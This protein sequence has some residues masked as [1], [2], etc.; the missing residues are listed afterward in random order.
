VAIERHVISLEAKDAVTPA[1]QKIATQVQRTSQQVEQG[2]QRAAR[3][4]QDWSRA[5]SGLG[6]A[7]GGIT[8]AATR[9]AQESEVSQ[10]RLQASIEA[11]GA[12]YDDYADAV[13]NAARSALNL[14][15]DDEEA[16]DALNALTQGTGDAS[17][18]LEDLALVEDIAR[19]RG[20]DLAAAAKIVIAAEQ[21]RIGSL[22]RLGIAIDENAS[23]E[24]A[25]AAL[26]TKFAGQ[27]EAYADTNAATWDRVQNSIENALEGA[28]GALVDYQGLILGVSTAGA[29]LGPLSDAFTAIG[30]KAKLAAAG[31]GALSLAMGPLGIAAAAAAGAA[32][33]YLLIKS[34]DGGD[35]SLKASEA[36]VSNLQQALADLA[37]EGVSSAVTQQIGN[38]AGTLQDV[39]RSSVETS[40]ELDRV[41]EAGLDYAQMLDSNLAQGNDAAADAARRQLENL[42]ALAEELDRD[43]LTGE[44]FTQMQQDLVDIFT[45]PNP[46]N[47]GLVEARLAELRAE[48]EAGTISADDLAW[49]IH[50]LN[51]NSD[52]Y[53]LTLEEQARQQAA[54]GNEMGNS[55]EEAAALA[56]NMKV[57]AQR[58]K[59][60]RAA[61]EQLNDELIALAGTIGRNMP[62]AAGN[63][64]QQVV[65]FTQGMV[66]AIGT[67]ADWAN[68]LVSTA[69]GVS[70]LD[71]I[72]AGGQLDAEDYNEVLRETGEINDA[73]ARAIGAANEIQVKQ[74]DIVSEGADAT[75]DYL[76]SIA[77]LPEA[78]Q[79]LALAWADQDLAGR[80]TEIA[81]MAG[82]FDQMGSAQQQAFA[83]MVESAA[84]TDP[85]LARV[86][87]SLGLIVEKTD[88][89]YELKV[90]TDQAKSDTELLID[91]IDRLTAAITGVPNVAV[92][93]TLDTAGF[94]ETWNALPD[95]KTIVTYTRFG[96]VIGPSPELALGGMVPWGGDT[97]AL[98]RMSR[99][100]TTLVGENG[101][102]LVNLPGGSTVIPNHASRYMTDR[103]GG[104]FVIQNMTVIAND[105]QSFMAQMRDY[106][107][108]MERR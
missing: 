14:A 28:G 81:E 62:E 51:E 10:Q 100:R 46:L 76:E 80:A 42:N 36:N 77:K 92:D 24:E 107:S 33:I 47:S 71:Q 82:Q 83:S 31:T 57:V 87:E 44:Q 38:F 98:G 19:A 26:Q 72:M 55:A 21:G 4:S 88:G 106:A 48:W 8:L 2:N 103:S 7:L 40:A 22:K 25:L 90:P 53:G 61:S 32:G 94:W 9:F 17:R 11:T 37:G 18:A 58:N 20:I 35:D 64:F 6:L 99:G 102:E 101:P 41:R 68:A 73:N 97:A 15:F 75:A 105:P 23:S 13:D 45:D 104:S 63:A 60:A 84:N 66:D 34:L 69:D 79:A 78:E 39:A 65:G 52:T 59:D 89:T 12:S 86:L 95:Q 1:L 30:G 3:S 49:N 70:R 91:A 5:A 56:E 29:A 93:A 27:A 67:S 85:Q 43:I 54:A 50:F 16:L 108:T 74:I 96:G